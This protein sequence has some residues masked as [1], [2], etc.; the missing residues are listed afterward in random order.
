MFLCVSASFSCLSLQNWNKALVAFDFSGKSTSTSSF[1]HLTQK[2]LTLQFRFSINRSQ[3]LKVNFCIQD[4]ILIQLLFYL[5][6][7]VL[8]FRDDLWLI[9]H[10]ELSW[11][12]VFLRSA[13]V[14]GKHFCCLVES[15]NT[16]RE[17]PAS[18]LNTTSTATSTA[19]HTSVKSV[20]KLFIS[21]FS[22]NFCST[23]FFFYNWSFFFGLFL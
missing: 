9:G 4:Y 11:D 6:T 10:F 23:L 20:H 14:I 16:N 22:S 1:M 17:P 3:R 5:C 13:L 12:F 19:S 2:V 21:I 8:M 18:Q 7:R 15:N